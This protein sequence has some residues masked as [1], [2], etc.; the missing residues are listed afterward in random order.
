MSL[1][2]FKDATSNDILCDFSY[3]YKYVFGGAGLELTARKLSV[4]F[5][6]KD[7]LSFDVQVAFKL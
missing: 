3:P 4:G 2:S 6:G 5:G 1:I 7:S